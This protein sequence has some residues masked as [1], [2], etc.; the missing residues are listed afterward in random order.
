MET[1]GDIEVSLSKEI[2]KQFEYT[3]RGK[4]SDIILKI[5]TSEIKGEFTLTLLNQEREPEEF[6]KVVSLVREVK[7]GLREK[8]IAKR[9]AI[10]YGKKPNE[11]YKIL[12]GE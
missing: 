6:K 3:I 1:I 8:E 5:S 10:I 11:V 7:K 12:K 9:I 4:I 2:T